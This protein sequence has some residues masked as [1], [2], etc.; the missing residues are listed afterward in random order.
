MEEKIIEI[1][2]N[3]NCK[4]L[5][6]IISKLQNSEMWGLTAKVSLNQ[7]ISVFFHSSVGSQRQ[8]W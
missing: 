1:L 7:Y 6:F 3:T 4:F 2:L 8:Y 5:V